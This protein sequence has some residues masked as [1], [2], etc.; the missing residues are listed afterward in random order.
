MTELPNNSLL[1]LLLPQSL[2]PPLP[3]RRRDEEEE[4]EEG[5][6]RKIKP[7]FPKSQA[8]AVPRHLCPCPV[9]SP[10]PPPPPN[11]TNRH[12]LAGAFPQRRPPAP[13][14]LPPN[15]PPTHTAGRKRERK[16]GRGV[17]PRRRQAASPA[18]GGTGVAGPCPP[19][20]ARGDS[21]AAVPRPRWLIVA[22]TE[23]PRV[24]PQRAAIPP[25]PGRQGL[26][27]SLVVTKWAADI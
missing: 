14:A 6:T 4:P 27:Q 10:R 25:H 24:P 17:C 19:Q 23:R 20:R 7:P 21:G 26:G 22:A 9:P 5:E 3:L 1:W 11:N 16:L 18:L 2:P 8:P 12:R 15:S 13:Q